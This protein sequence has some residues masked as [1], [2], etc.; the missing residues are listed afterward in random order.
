MPPKKKKQETP[1]EPTPEIV[2]TDCEH[3]WHQYALE[4]ASI[5][6]I[7]PNPDNPCPTCGANA[8]PQREDAIATINPEECGHLWHLHAMEMA[9]IYGQTELTNPCPS[10][11]VTTPY[12]LT[13]WTFQD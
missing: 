7:A 11:G 13:C 5:H 6:G 4:L 9:T 12:C 8:L 2:N 1:V 10:C 3:L